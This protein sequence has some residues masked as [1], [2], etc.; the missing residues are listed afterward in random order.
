MC[1]SKLSY[2][3][4][5]TI[6]TALCPITYRGYNYDFTTGLYYLQSRYYNPE[7][8]RFLNC[9]DTAILLATQGETH[10][11]NLFAYC[12]NNPV[13]RV[14]YNGQYSTDL[15]TS[16]NAEIVAVL[17]FFILIYNGPI[18]IDVYAHKGVININIAKTSPYMNGTFSD[19][20]L[21]TYQLFD[22]QY[23]ETVA[24]NIFYVLA[25]SATYIFYEEFANLY[26]S[27][28]S[29]DN[30]NEKISKREFLFS[31]EC[32]ADEIKAHCEGHWFSLDKIDATGYSTLL[33]AGVGFNKEE[34]ETRC[35]SID[36]AE[37]D[38]AAFDDRTAFGYFS[39]IRECYKNTKADPYWQGSLLGVNFRTYQN[40]R[41]EWKK[42]KISV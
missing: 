8:G 22:M 32:V 12:A 4:E 30:S 21:A 37:Q 7:W 15:T 38:A 14:D 5:A 20:L 17:T 28:I 11:A 1:I 39:G 34:L 2:E 27:K 3:E 41:E 29:D 10:N 16:V 40:V 25:V 33:Y 36:I 19:V 18:D 31:D 26:N 6:F 9:D 24:E 23:G 35:E 42:Q 13:N